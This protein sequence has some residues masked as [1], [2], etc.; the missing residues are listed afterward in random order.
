MPQQEL[1]LDRIPEAARYLGV[2]FNVGRDEVIGAYVIAERI[3]AEVF[4]STSPYRRPYIRRA[5][6][7]FHAGLVAEAIEDQGQTVE[8]HLRRTPIAGTGSNGAL[9]TFEHSFRGG[10]TARVAL[11]L[12]I[13]GPLETLLVK[14]AEL[15][16]A[17]KDNQDSP[18]NEART[19]S[20]LRL[21]RMQLI[22]LASRSNPT[23]PNE[24]SNQWEATLDL[25]AGK[26]HHSKYDGIPGTDPEII[27]HAAQD[28]SIARG[29]FI[30][31]KFNPPLPGRSLS[32]QL[33]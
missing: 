1:I 2:P 21:A 29:L 5:L 14:D 3:R 10:Q 11:A 20:R 12:L 7:D 27:N 23:L 24:E 8:S 18:D 19:K 32:V 22:L 16:K 6:R 13:E 4:A 17:I 30:S 15:G 26:F 9:V 31:P 33:P 28:W 25:I